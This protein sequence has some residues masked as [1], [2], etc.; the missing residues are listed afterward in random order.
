MEKIGVGE[1]ARRGNDLLGHHCHAKI[2]EKRSHS[3]FHHLL[4]VELYCGS[5]VDRQR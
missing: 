2:M 4:S 5:D 3:H 1:P